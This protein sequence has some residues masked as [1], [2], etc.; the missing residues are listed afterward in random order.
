M[1]L[2][3]FGTGDFARLV[4]HY[5][6][7]LRDLEVCAFTV[8][9]NR[10]AMDSFCGKPIIPFER[11]EHTFPPSLF[12]MFSA[13]GYRTMRSRKIVY[14]QILGKGY[15]C[16]NIVHPRAIVSGDLVMGKNNIIMPAAHI[17]PFISIGNNNIVWSDSLICHDSKIG[18]HNFIAAGSILGGRCNM[19]DCCFIGFNTTIVQNRFIANET[20]TGAKSLILHDTEPCSKYFGLPA[21]KQGSHAQKGIC[22]DE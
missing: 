21:V 8:H 5:C 10:I 11:I 12:G 9:Q 19:E 6:G 14:D 2:V 4:C 17:E 1:N 13:I 7:D 22:I 3:I 20:L 16:I 15:D 18:D